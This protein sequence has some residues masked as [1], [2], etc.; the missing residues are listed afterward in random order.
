MQ[1]CLFQPWVYLNLKKRERGRKGDQEEEVERVL[2]KLDFL[3]Q[4]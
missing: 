4:I 2:V 1:K 3:F